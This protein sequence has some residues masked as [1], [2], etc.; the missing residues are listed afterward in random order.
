M[1]GLVEFTHYQAEA[2]LICL[3]GSVI[4][5]GMLFFGARG[6]ERAAATA[7]AERLWTAALL[8]AV[9]PSLVAPTLAAFGV[10]LRPAPAPMEFEAMRMV[11]ASDAPLK[12]ASAT[13]TPALLTMEQ[14][15]GGGALLYVYGVF[16][17]LFL[18]AARQAALQY[19]VARAEFVVAGDFLGRIEDWA[20]D[21]GVRMPAIK[22]SHHVSSVCIT[23]VFRQTVLIPHG[24]ELRVSTDDLVLM[25]AHELA[26]VRRGDTRLF[27]ATQ[28]ARVL[29]WFNPLVGRIAAHAELAAEESA[30]ALVLRKGVDRRVYAA[31]FVEGL[32][33]A[34][35]RMNVQPALAPSFTPQDRHGRRRR[36]NSILSAEPPRRMPLA[37]RLMLSAAASSVALIAVGQAALAVDPDSAAVRRNSLDEMPLVG[38]ITSRFGE[39]SAVSGGDRSPAHSGLDIKAPNGAKVFAPGDGVVVEATDL[40]NRSPA[41]GKVVVI[42]H[43]HGLVTRYA[44]LDSYRVKRGQR[45]KTGDVIAAVGATGKVTGPHLHFETLQDGAAVDPADV[46]VATAPDAEP[47]IA[48]IDVIDALEPL[49]APEPAAAAAPLAEPAPVPAPAPKAPKPMRFSYTM[50]TAPE[51][52]GVPGVRA[53]GPSEKFREFKF[54]NPA[55]AA[56]PPARFAFAGDAPMALMV[57]DIEQRLLGAA[58]GEDIGSYNLTFRSGDKVYR[59]SSDE[60]MN[61]EKRAELREALKEMK[62]HSDA[63]RKEAAKFR[64]ESWRAEIDRVKA[65][66]AE[67]ADSTAAD[68][69]FSEDD[70]AQL[71]LDARISRRDALEAERE[72]LEEARDGLDEAAA[73]DFE[74]ALS[75]LDDAESDLEDADMSG[76]D[77]A[78]ARTA[79]REQRRQ[80]QRDG[81]FQKRQVETSRRQIDVR[82]DAIDRA[83]ET[84]D[85]EE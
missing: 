1:S 15:I 40:Y 84:L 55:I 10:S 82:I 67:R 61:A 49:S 70:I 16:L 24:I 19:A 4:W 27:T 46:V 33:F 9:L 69:A 51:V 42:D 81:E 80:M 50:A 52:A 77:L 74:E 13:V 54:A 68:F 11:V 44:H 59:F 14:A 37:K 39:K 64:K 28:L 6:L 31:C 56:A 83:L 30:D 20:S 38:E 75:D 29:F 45:V 23:G 34:A 43:G 48:P 71:R 53:F 7:S 85:D 18:W 47:A 26:H 3:A 60:P 73:T 57:E 58:N 21:L 12:E 35:H 25:C 62:K 17:T 72:A 65:Q 79:L 78:A 36:L 5:A 76:D 8:F 2:L 22:R 32:K 41:W 66:A 63:A